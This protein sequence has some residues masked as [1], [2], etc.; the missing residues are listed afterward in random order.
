MLMH[1]YGNY[2]DYQVKDERLLMN[3]FVRQRWRPRHREQTTD[4][5]IQS[6]NRGWDQLRKEHGDICISLCKIR[7]SGNLLCATG[8]STSCSVRTQ[9]TGMGREEGGSLSSKGTYIYPWL[10]HP[11][12]CQKTTQDCKIIVFPLKKQ[13]ETLCSKNKIKGY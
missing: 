10:S 4:L 2:K 5:W 11:D 6:R 13:K 9:R 1:G 12:V 8:S 3:L 7:T